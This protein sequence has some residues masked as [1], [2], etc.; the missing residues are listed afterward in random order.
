MNRTD[1]L[2]AVHEALRHAGGS[3]QRADALADALEVSVRTIKRDISAL[4]QAGAPI[5]AR[6]GRGGGYVLDASATLPP[7]AL[8]PSQA[9]ALA[10][11]VAI[12]P[13]GSPFGLDAKHAADRVLATLSDATRERA[14]TLA[15][16]IW[17]LPGEH[18]TP[19]PPGVVRSIEQS[20]ADRRV[21]RITYCD[22][23]GQETQRTIEPVMAAWGN[24]RWYVV[25]QCRLRDD[26]RWF[27][28]DRI[29]DA[30]TT[31]EGY[32]PRPVADVGT[33]PPTARP[34]DP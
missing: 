1:R 9:V 7:V 13:P 26:I 18:V 15:D 2:H 29:V 22:D 34:V 10:V 16:Q 19:A 17:V 3:G 31:R 33:P 30:R 27:R 11:A 12:L 5:W 21:L 24:D 6:P 20:L 4:Q 32:Q 23:R 8:T 25:A 14:A 28:M